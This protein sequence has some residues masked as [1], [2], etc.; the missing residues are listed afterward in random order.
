MLSDPLPLGAV[1]ALAL[2]A[3]AVWVGRRASKPG[4]RH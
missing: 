3:L 4:K 1:V 2:L